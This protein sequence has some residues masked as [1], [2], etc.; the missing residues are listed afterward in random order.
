MPIL[1]VSK[2][3]MNSAVQGDFRVELLRDLRGNDL[4]HL[5]DKSAYFHNHQELKSY[6][7][8]RMKIPVTDLFVI[9]Y[10]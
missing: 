7:A 8:E 2:A 4:S 10:A 3:Y 1:E 6:L 9:G 5:V